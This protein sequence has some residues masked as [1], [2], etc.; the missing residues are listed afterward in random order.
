MALVATDF[1]ATQPALSPDPVIRDILNL[2]NRYGQTEA[3]VRGARA[4]CLD[5]IIYFAMKYMTEHHPNP[6][7]L[8]PH[9]AGP[10]AP[11]RIPDRYWDALCELVKEVKGEA[12]Q[13]NLKLLTN[14]FERATSLIMTNAGPWL[15]RVSQDHLRG[16]DTEDYWREWLGSNGAHDF[17]GY[18]SSLGAQGIAFDR[19]KYKEKSQLYRWEI[20]WDQGFWKRRK[21][22]V[23]ADTTYAA[24]DPKMAKWITIDAVAASP[25]VPAGAPATQ[26]FPQASMGTFVV[27]FDFKLYIR[28]EGRYWH[29]SSFL[30]GQPVMA[31][32]LICIRQGVIRIITP[33][34]GHYKPSMQNMR[35]FV[36]KYREQLRSCVI[37]PDPANYGD[38]YT[39]SD[40]LAGNMQAGRRVSQAT[41]DR[42]LTSAA[43]VP[44]P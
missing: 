4:K 11:P 15:E 27:D 25:P 8:G 1:K 21:N 40:F 14:P 39:V 9:P 28:H 17:W 24:G 36:D 3:T 12:D 23:L 43:S 38:F 16:H 34:S 13:L 26:L 42:L 33:E 2:I 10:D 37:M 19:I 31:A 30:S 44:I 41:L 29:H 6:E 5:Q 32:G 18:L 7:I 35:R 20:Y 22:K